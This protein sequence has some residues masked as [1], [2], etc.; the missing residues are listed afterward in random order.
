MKKEK[1]EMLILYKKASELSECRYFLKQD[2]W[3]LY[4]IISI[5]LF[6]K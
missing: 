4:I 5:Y 6:N 2:N 3:T 1:I